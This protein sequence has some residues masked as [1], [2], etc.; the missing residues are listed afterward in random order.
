MEEAYVTVLI[1][2][3]ATQK[4][5]FYVSNEKIKSENFSIFSGSFRKLQAQK[6]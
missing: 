3:K 5:Y 4:F 1:K 6:A 2:N